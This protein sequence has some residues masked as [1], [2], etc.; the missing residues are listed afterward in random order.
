MPIS[1]ITPPDH[2]QYPIPQGEFNEPEE[3]QPDHA[4]LTTQLYEVAA[5]LAATST[6]LADGRAGLDS[7]LFEKSPVPLGIQYL[8]E[9]NRSLQSLHDKKIEELTRKPATYALNTIGLSTVVEQWLH[10][11]L[12]Q[13]E[14]VIGGTILD[15]VPKG[16]VQRFYPDHGEWF[17]ERALETS[18]N[19]PY[20]VVH[21]VIEDDHRVR[22]S[23]SKQ[24]QENLNHGYFTDDQLTDF[25]IFVE[26]YHG[27]VTERVYAPK[28]PKH[29]KS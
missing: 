8:H 26:K 23:E 7:T 10:K 12:L 20:Q 27:A 25:L 9:M 11:Q 19:K 3:I 5:Q 6:G 17:L 28:Q 1:S 2:T 15:E 21:Y 22:M 14:G 24:G 16:H 4:R 18:P 29:R 13:D